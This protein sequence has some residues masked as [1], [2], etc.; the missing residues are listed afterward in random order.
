[1]E[2]PRRKLVFVK[3]H[4]KLL[5]HCSFRYWLCSN[6]LL[7][8]K[9]P[10]FLPWPNSS[11]FLLWKNLIFWGW[12]SFYSRKILSGDI[13]LTHVKSQDQ[14]KETFTKSLD[15]NRWKFICSKLDLYDGDVSWHSHN[16]VY[17][18]IVPIAGLLTLTLTM[19][20]G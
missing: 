11:T 4:Q 5:W 8:A 9:T 6:F 15:H 2:K 14:F 16:K 17:P 12:L 18:L 20:N 19:A 3:K 13:S 1:M 10:S 7:V